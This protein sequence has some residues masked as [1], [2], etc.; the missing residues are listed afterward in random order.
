MKK[1]EGHGPTLTEK[2]RSWNVILSFYDLLYANRPLLSQD[3]Y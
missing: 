2:F 1:K 3:N